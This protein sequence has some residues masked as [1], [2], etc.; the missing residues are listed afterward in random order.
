MVFPKD[1]YQD[2]IQLVIDDAESVLYADDTA[3]YQPF[4]N[5]FEW[6]NTNNLYLNQNNFGISCHHVDK[7]QNIQDKAHNLCGGK[8]INKWSSVDDTIKRNALLMVFAC[9]HCTQPEMYDSYFTRIC[10]TAKLCV[11][12]IPC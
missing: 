10:R 5:V 12:I 11:E 4:N 2:Y 9:L 3:V 8:K 7:F 1:Q 6:L